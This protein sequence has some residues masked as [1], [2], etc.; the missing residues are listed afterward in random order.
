MRFKN[1]DHTFAVCAYKESEYLEELLIS[2][3]KQTIKTNIIIATSTPNAHIQ[4]L[5]DEYGV[6]VFV[7][8]GEKGIAAD[9]N[10]ALISAQTPL[11][12]IAHQDDTYEPEY[13]ER[14]IAAINK[15]KEPIMA[16]SHYAEIRRDKKVF[17]NRLLSIKK[18]LLLPIKV[19]ARSIFLRRMSLAFGNSICCPSVTYVREKMTDHLFDTSLKN[20]LDW[21]QWEI[22]SR[23]KGSFIYIDEPLMCHRIYLGSTTT[24]MI[25]NRTR[26][27]ED[28]AIFCKFW[29]QP[30][31]KL[32][33]KVYAAGEKSNSLD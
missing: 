2:L 15:E 3:K 18:C 29:P 1:K 16:F 8:T 7:N 30:I 10:F 21:N 23:L 24:E 27:N 31:A 9:W 12:T 32:I 22:L 11:V 17:K 28:Y 26:I 5:A 19:S 6:P 33:T 20:S 4:S 25:E 14:I 13:A